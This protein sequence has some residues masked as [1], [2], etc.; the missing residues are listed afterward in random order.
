M[1][2]FELVIIGVTIAGFAVLPT[3]F[4]FVIQHVFNVEIRSI[5]GY[6]AYL[7]ETSHADEIIGY[8]ALER[9]GRGPG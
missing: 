1:V 2:L 3:T 7:E 6:A 8:N 5:R 4:K 9:G